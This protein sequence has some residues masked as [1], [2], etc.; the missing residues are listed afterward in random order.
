MKRAEHSIVANRG[1]D[2]GQQ[3][4]QSGFWDDAILCHV[5]EAQLSKADHYGVTFCRY[6]KERFDSGAKEVEIPNP[7]PSLLIDFASACVWRY[8]ASRG[9][10][11]PERLLGR[12]AKL[13]E[14]SLFFGESFDPML[15]VSAHGF[16]DEDRNSLRIG[17]H[18]YRHTELAI[19]F[20]RLVV[21]GLYFDLKLD[22]RKTPAA[23]AIFAVNTATTITVHEDLPQ[24]IMADP[25]LGPALRRMHTRRPSKTRN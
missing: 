16:F 21:S 22:A 11:R 2:T 1:N 3:T 25:T 6:F 10:R 18:P 15:M 7:S 14:R 4:L 13:I 9:H 5:H 17:A 8:A 23:M 24:N 19:R 12:Y 20:W